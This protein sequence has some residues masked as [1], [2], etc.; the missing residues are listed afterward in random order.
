MADSVSKGAGQ[1]SHDEKVD[2]IRTEQVQGSVA[3]AAA[4]KSHPPRPWS[5]PLLQLYSCCIVA[6][7]CSTLNGITL[8]WWK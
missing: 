2:D 4:R 5:R 8:A 1:I 3:V 6:W 7:L